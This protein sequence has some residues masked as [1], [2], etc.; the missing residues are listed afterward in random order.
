MKKERSSREIYKRLA[1][2]NA[3][4]YFKKAISSTNIYESEFYIKIKDSCLEA[5]RDAENAPYGTFPDENE[6]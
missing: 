1:L 3:M 6:H 4:I 2:H 5:Y